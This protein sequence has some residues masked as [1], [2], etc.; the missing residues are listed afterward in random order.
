MRFHRYPFFLLL[1]AALGLAFAPAITRASIVISATRVIYEAKSGEKTVRLT[2]KGQTPSL[3][4]AWLDTGAPQADRETLDVPFVLSPPMSRVD[5]GKSQTLRVI[6]S[7]EPLPQDRESIFW[8]N[9]LDIPARPDVAADENFLQL[10]FR[11]RIKFFFRPEGLVGT[12]TEAPTQLSWQLGTEAGHPVLRV[13]NPT[14]YH[15]SLASVELGGNG[16]SLG[17]QDPGMLAPFE[18]RALEL[19]RAIPATPGMRVRY[20]FINDY[21]GVTDSEA[22]LQGLAR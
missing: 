12:A 7:G 15:I 19:P 16:A 14:P 5:P 13:A 3:V 9:V 4:Q 17:V 1:T 20:R 2:N 8:L 18:T 10:S 11:S 6:Y 22:A 21:G